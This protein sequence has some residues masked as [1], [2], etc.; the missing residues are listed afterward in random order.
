MNRANT[1]GAIGT[2]FRFEW[3]CLLITVMGFCNGMAVPGFGDVV[4]SQ[5]GACSVPGW[6]IDVA[7]ASSWEDFPREFCSVRDG[8]LS[9]LDTFSQPSLRRMRDVLEPS[10]YEALSA[11]AEMAV[12]YNAQLYIHASPSARLPER[13]CITALAVDITEYPP[14]GWPWMGKVGHGFLEPDTLS[15]LARLPRLAHL[16]LYDL[17]IG[18]DRST[19]ADVAKLKQLR[20]LGL[21]ADT[22]DAEVALL[23]G[24]EKLRFLNASGTEVIGVG[25]AECRLDG[26]TMLDLR[27]SSFQGRNLQHLNGCSGLRTL[28]LSGARIGDEDIPFLLQLRNLEVLTLDHTA[29]TAGGLMRLA[30]LPNLRFLSIRAL[31]LSGDERRALAATL[32]HA[33]IAVD[34]PP[35]LS[36]ENRQWFLD[37]SNPT[38]GPILWLRRAAE[39]ESGQGRPRDLVQAM[40]LYTLVERHGGLERVSESVR[41][42]ARERV[43]GLREHLTDSEVR[44]ALLRADLLCGMYRQSQFAIQCLA[45]LPY[46]M[47]QIEFARAPFP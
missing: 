6:M 45:G 27:Y 31:G 14:G 33:V 11:F 42:K 16:E 7:V 28:L 2:Q 37:M 9:R 47:Y 3:T 15:L 4:R 22:R 21:P 36:P 41:Q 10:D 13:R 43:E 1:R 18:N 29:V 46:P 30:S 38:G 12:G 34:S 25:F 40:A 19:F 20:Y 24:L 35:R 5:C 26:L 8:C 32:P 39:Y 44:E 23:S 17:W